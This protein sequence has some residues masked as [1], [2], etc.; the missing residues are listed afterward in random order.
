MPDPSS[1]ELPEGHRHRNSSR[2]RG[3]LPLVAV[4]VVALAALGLAGWALLRPAPIATPAAPDYTDAQRAEAKAEICTVFNT[5]RTGVT[6]NTNLQAPGGEGD[7]LGNLAIAAN[8]RL[9]LYDGGQ[10]LLAR[11]DPATPKELADAVRTFANNLMDVG[12]AATAGVPNTDPN[13]AARLRDA[14]TSNSTIE[15]LCQ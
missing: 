7:V 11:L 9:S 2:G 13:Q 10:Y 4:A 5:V 12:A 15:G 1:A 14:D 3:T 8:A 6:Q